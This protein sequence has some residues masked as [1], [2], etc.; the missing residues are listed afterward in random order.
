MNAT[1]YR[2]QYCDIVHPLPA[3]EDFGDGRCKLAPLQPRLH[4]S[5]LHY[6]LEHKT[7]V[8]PGY[9]ECSK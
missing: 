2:C 4:E 1:P 9:Q 6:C 8:V 7:Y 5:G 3:I